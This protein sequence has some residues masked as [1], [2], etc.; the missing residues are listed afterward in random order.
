MAPF[1][2][3]T[4]QV[5]TRGQTRFDY[6]RHFR[7]N[8]HA[9]SL[10][11]AQ[12]IFFQRELEH[13][14]PEMFEFEFAQINA[15]RIFPIDRSAGGAVRSITWRQFTKYGNAQIVS[16]YA[17]DINCVNVDGEEFTTPVR[18][19]AVKATWSIDEIRAAQAENR[20]LDRMLAEAA[21]EAMMREENRS[22]FE[23]DAA[24]N[25]QGLAS[26]GTGISQQPTPS[27]NSWLAGATAADDIL[28]DL[29]FLSNTVV[30]TSGDRE[31]PDT[32]MIPTRHFNAI[33]S[34]ARSTTSDT[35]I[36]K[37]FTN[38]NPY[39]NEVIPV[40]ELDTAFGAGTGPVA[41]AYRRDPSKIRMQVPLD[42]EQFAPQEHNMTV[43][44]IWHMRIGGLTVFKP[45]SLLIGTGIGT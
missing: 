43:Q 27:G 30:E 21:R 32:L 10:D 6:A 25:L 4:T 31:I 37:Y 17:D 5:Q 33:S 12:S 39:I 18:G 8:P 20:P 13:I 29:N 22:V 42:I 24:F 26:A 28:G 41:V 11:T 45:A 23:G 14:I 35:T 7:F 19:I 36:L 2:P 9:L 40:R 1:A 15:R 38:N 34:R 44:V 16:D 3:P